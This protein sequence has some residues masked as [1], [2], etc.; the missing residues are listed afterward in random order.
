VHRAVLGEVVDGLVAHGIGAIGIVPSPLR[1]ADGNV[2]F[3]LHA[4]HGAATIAAAD[5]DAVVTAVHA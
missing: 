5:L 1:G 4:R 3:L 2:E